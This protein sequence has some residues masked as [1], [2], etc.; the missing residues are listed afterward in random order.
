MLQFVG[1]NKIHI[2]QTDGKY[3]ISCGKA[4]ILKSHLL[5]CIK[6]ELDRKNTKMQQGIGKKDKHVYV[7][8]LIYKQ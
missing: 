4:Y 6:M 7:S 3:C 1:N 2:I 8:K 5:D